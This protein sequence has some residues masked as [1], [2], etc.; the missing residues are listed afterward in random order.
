ML[1]HRQVCKCKSRCNF[2]VPVNSKSAHPPPSRAIPRHLTSVKLRTMGNL[3]QN[4]PC[5][6][7]HL[8]FESKRL[9]AVGNK[10]IVFLYSKSQQ[11]IIIKI[12]VD[13]NLN[14]NSSQLFITGYVHLNKRFNAWKKVLH[15]CFNMPGGWRI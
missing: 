9:S 4:G 3:T 13:T 10:R 14:P 6:V 11:I 5:P 1:R 15:S 12:A 8:T 2:Y 7:G